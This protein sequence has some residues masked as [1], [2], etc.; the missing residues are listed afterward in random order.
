MKKNK[1]TIGDLKVK[2][3]ITSESEQLKGGL[4]THP[5]CY[6]S[7]NCSYDDGCVTAQA[8]QPTN[9]NCL[10]SRLECTLVHC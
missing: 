7:I 4:Q 10:V 2:S 5:V 9:V 6:N 3:F 1:L 8:C